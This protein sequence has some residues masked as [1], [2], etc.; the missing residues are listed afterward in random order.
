MD[1]AGLLNI[2][3]SAGTITRPVIGNT[4]LLKVFKW[5]PAQA[6]VRKSESRVQLVVSPPSP[7]EAFVGER[8]VAVL[9]E[10]LEDT[11]EGTLCP[12]TSRYFGELPKIK[13]FHGDEMT[14]DGKVWAKNCD[15]IAKISIRAGAYRCR[16]NCTVVGQVVART[17]L[18]PNATQNLPLNELAHPLVDTIFATMPEVMTD[19]AIMN[20]SSVSLWNNIDEYTRGMVMLSYQA[21][22][23]AMTETFHSSES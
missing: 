20:R 3:T 2:S 5:E 9:V 8:Y 18:Q 19:M 1:E 22:W 12:E 16:T 23:N 6:T 21:V 13:F 4:A 17:L 11:D 15:T 10:R 14:S 7:K